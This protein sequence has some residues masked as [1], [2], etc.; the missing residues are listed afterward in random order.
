M[1]YKEA[2][3]KLNEFNSFMKV[4]NTQITIKIIIRV[5]NEKLSDDY[6]RKLYIQRLSKLTNLPD[7]GNYN[8]MLPKGEFIIQP[9]NK[10]VSF[11]PFEP[12][13]EIKSTPEIEK[14][15]D[16]LRNLTITNFKK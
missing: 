4:I 6:I 8:V 7:T 1:N 10:Y 2:A 3:I 16:I 13:G 11:M 5:L 14:Q 12:K 15:I 9:N